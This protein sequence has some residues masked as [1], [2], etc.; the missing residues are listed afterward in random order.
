MKN[1]LKSTSATRSFEMLLSGINENEIL[2]V[3]ALKSVRGG[4]GEASGGEPII[5]V[6]KEI[7]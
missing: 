6:P 7:K 2:S 3:Q 1:L 4:D 5:I